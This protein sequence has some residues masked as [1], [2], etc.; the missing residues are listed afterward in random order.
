MYLFLGKLYNILILENKMNIIYTYTYLCISCSYI[1]L[2]SLV[3]IMYHLCL[4]YALLCYALPYQ[5]INI[6]CIFICTYTYAISIFQK[7]KTRWRK[8]N[9]FY[10]SSFLMG[11][12]LNIWMSHHM[13]ILASTIYE[14]YSNIRTYIQIYWDGYAVVGMAKDRWWFGCFN[15]IRER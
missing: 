12:Q 7:M 10:S 11:I 8:H 2:L 13:Y 5:Y 9:I 3:Y 15:K 1:L 6:V 14:R 4:C